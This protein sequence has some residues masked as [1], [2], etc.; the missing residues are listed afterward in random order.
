[1]RSGRQFFPCQPP[2]SP[3]RLS[4][5]LFDLPEA[6]RHHCVIL[7]FT[8]LT[9]SNTNVH[10]CKPPTL[11]DKGKERL[12]WSSGAGFQWPDP[13]HCEL[14]KGRKLTEFSY[15]VTLLPRKQTPEQ[16]PNHFLLRNHG[17]LQ[18]SISGRKTSEVVCFFF[19]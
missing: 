19:F 8:S 18:H 1:M 12:G 14:Q 11:H 7:P 5:Y 6:F 10:V 3:D 9:L 17:S 13:S 15:A 16:N 2:G 4:F